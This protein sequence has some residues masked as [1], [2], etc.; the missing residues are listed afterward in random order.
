MTQLILNKLT[1]Q[2]YFLP[3][4]KVYFLFLCFKFKFP[5][6]FCMC[7]FV[8]SAELH[9]FLPPVCGIT[10][11]RMSSMFKEGGIC[12]L[13]NKNVSLFWQRSTQVGMNL[14]SLLKKKSSKESDMKGSMFL[15]PYLMNTAWKDQAATCARLAHT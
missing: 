13:D 3:V 5:I 11:W 2:L 1:R 8:I 15:L 9:S 10:V 7:I 14:P 4:S 12:Q 6:C